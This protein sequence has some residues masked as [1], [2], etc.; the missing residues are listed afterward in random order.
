MTETREDFDKRKAEIEKYFSLLEILEKDEIKISYKEKSRIKK[1]VVDNELLKILKANGYLL[2][3]NL[4]EATCRN[5]LIQILTSIQG[6]SLPLA[7]LSETVQTLWV[8]QKVKGVNNSLVKET[9][10]EKRIFAIIKDVIGE[11]IIEFKDTIA[12]AK[13]DGNDM[14][15]LSGNIDADQIRILADNYGFDARVG[16]DNEKAG[17]SL[18]DI[19]IMR[20]KLAHGRIT[21]ADCGKDCSV[22]QMI[23]YKNNCIKYLG[24]ILDSIEKYITDESFK[25]EKTNKNI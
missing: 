14:F 24:A 25:L 1:Q 5:A 16:R 20:N 19:R 17:A 6:H 8:Q 23:D 12:K 3:Y 4:L 7:S 2:I 18:S 11:T 10:V 9:T 13:N 21:F 22:I 15:N